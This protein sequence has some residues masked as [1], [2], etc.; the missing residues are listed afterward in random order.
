MRQMS[1][2]TDSFV[3]RVARL[4]GYDTM[5]PNDIRDFV[6]KLKER[7]YSAWGAAQELRRLL[8]I[9]GMKL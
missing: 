3:M 4:V 7:G 2:D 9:N 8:D 6:V 5:P 1:D